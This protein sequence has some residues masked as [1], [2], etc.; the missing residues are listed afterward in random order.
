VSVVVVFIAVLVAI[1]FHRYEVVFVIV[2]LVVKSAFFLLTEDSLLSDHLRKFREGSLDIKRD[3]V[4][5]GNGLL[6]L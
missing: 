6:Y 5:C 3:L 1:Y 2:L 4:A